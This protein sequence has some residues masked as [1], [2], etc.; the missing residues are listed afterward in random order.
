MPGCATIP[1]HTGLLT[2][3]EGAGNRLVPTSRLARRGD[4]AQLVAIYNYY[5]EHSIATFDT[6]PTTVEDRAEW[7][8]TFSEVGPYRLLVACDNDRVLGC[9]PAR[10]LGRNLRHRH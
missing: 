4:L 8:E 6:E 9:E 7:F 2:S 5:I 3:I 1:A 10:V